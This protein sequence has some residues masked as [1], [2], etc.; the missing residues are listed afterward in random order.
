[1]AKNKDELVILH[2][3]DLHFGKEKEFDRSVVL[4]SLMDRF[5]TDAKNGLKPEIVIVTGDIAFSGA[6]DEYKQAKL[7]FDDLL[8]SLNLLGEQLFLIPGNHDVNRGAYRRSDKLVFESMGDLNLEL[9]RVQDRNDLMKGMNT[10]FD[11]VEKNYPHLKPVGKNLVPFVHS[12]HS[13]A[14][15]KIGIVGL[16][17]AWMCRDSEDSGKIAVGE[18]QIS[19]AKKQLDQLEKEGELCKTIWLTHHP[20]QWLR[21]DDRGGLCRVLENSILLSGHLHDSEGQAVQTQEGIAFYQFQAGGVYLGAEADYPARYQVMT[22]DWQ[23]NE[24]RLAYRSFS[25]S[26]RHWVLDGERGLDGIGLFEHVEYQACSLRES[27]FSAQDTE[28]R[29]V[30]YPPLPTSNIDIVQENILKILSKRSIRKFCMYFENALKEDHNFSKNINREELVKAWVEREPE[31]NLK[32]LES[33]TFDYFDEID[34]S[35]ENLKTFQREWEAAVSLLGWLVLTL[36]DKDW[37][38]A[39]RHELGENE[40]M[41]HLKIPVETDTGVEVGQASFLGIKAEFKLSEKDTSLSGRRKID[42]AAKIEPGWATNEKLLQ[43]KQIIWVT[44][45]KRPAPLLFL[46]KDDQELNET[47][48]TLR[49]RSRRRE[50]YYL[51]T[52]LSETADILN[53]EE[54][55]RELKR[56][57]PSLNVI[58][59]EVGEKKILVM[60][61]I[62]LRVFVREFLKFEP[63]WQ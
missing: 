42:V 56:D 55:Y 1:M 12:Y 58:T 63:E 8:G 48:R 24:I 9:E 46:E 61:E 52:D 53:D 23:K 2:L 20:L 45:F 28:Y 30:K 25:Q 40:E 11:F 59:M 57:L 49:I 14:G 50:D 27:G 15:Q 4:E 21:E 62:K 47:L 37:L 54:L 32:I 29:Q 13:E 43:I 6:L 16:N 5:G 44:V 36:V 33:I 22:L 7:F 10:Y 34:I 35:D 39:T 41:I 31:N 18:Y 26:Q 3:S 17:S 51:I 60:V 19:K 38:E